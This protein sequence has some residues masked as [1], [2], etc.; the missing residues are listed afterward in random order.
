MKKITLF[1]LMLISLNQHLNAQ[2]QSS[3]ITPLGISS[4][5]IS[6]SS[7]SDVTTISSPTNSQLIYN[8][9]ASI[10][11]VDADGSEVTLSNS[12]VCENVDNT[13]TGITLPASICAGQSMPVSFTTSSTSAS[14]TVELLWDFTYQYLCGGPSNA[15]TIVLNTVTTTTNSTSIP[16]QATFSLVINTSGCITGSGCGTQNR[17]DN[18]RIRITPADATQGLSQSLTKVYSIADCPPPCLALLK[19]ASVNTTPPAPTD[20][21]STGTITKQANSTNGSIAATNKITGNARVT[22]QA[23]NI[24]LNAGFKA[25][26][27]TVFKAQV[28]GC[29]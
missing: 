7:M 22:Y 12:G 25:D 23:K 11:G 26:K 28:G 29:Q 9:N 6:L 4:P 24:Q 5:R 1:L 14:Y 20:D 8:T 27:G 21:I 18:Y 3:L 19:L 15:G 16:V 10:T 17:C 13:I 2:T